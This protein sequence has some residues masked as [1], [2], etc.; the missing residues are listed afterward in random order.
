MATG[1]QHTQ[2]Q[3]PPTGLPNQSP[4]P[5]SL[6][7]PRLVP[8]GP[9]TAPETAQSSQHLLFSPTSSSHRNPSKALPLHC[10]PVQM[11][12]DPCRGHECDD[13]PGPA[14][15]PPMAHGQRPSIDA[16]PWE[17]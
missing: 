9:P 10:V 13:P 16:A 15:G 4:Q 1:L 12:A 5:A 7:P 3:S 14:L 17:Q 11:C 6:T 8:Q 2:T